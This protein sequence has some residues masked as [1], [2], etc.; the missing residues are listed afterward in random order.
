[1]ILSKQSIAKRAFEQKMIE[2]FFPDKIVVRGRSAGLSSAS[3]DMTIGH[4]LTLGVNPAFVLETHVMLGETLDGD[5]LQTLRRRLAANP[6]Y[7]ALAFTQEDLKMPDD[8]SAQVADK[9]SHARL[10]CSAFNTFIDPGFHGNLTLELVNLSDQEIH[11]KKGDPIVQLIFS[12][13][14]EPTCS[15]YR[16]KYQHQR[17]VAQQVIYED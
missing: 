4:D 9:S 7:K 6:S 15:P 10:F 14:D 17:K 11:F 8:V 12:Q 5:G 1:M 16:G 2:P 13:L 3:Y